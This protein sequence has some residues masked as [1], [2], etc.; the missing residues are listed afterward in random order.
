VAFVLG[1]SGQL[2]DG[3]TRLLMPDRLELNPL[4]VALGGLGSFGAKVAL[5]GLLLVLAVTAREARRV[6]VVTWVLIAAALVG[7]FGVATNLPGVVWP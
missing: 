6:E 3:L 1:V 4:S 2:M 5:I 7:W